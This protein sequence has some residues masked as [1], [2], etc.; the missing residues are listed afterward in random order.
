M[1]LIPLT[2]ESEIRQARETMLATL[3]RGCSRIIKRITWPSGG[4]EYSVHWNPRERFWFSSDYDGP[5]RWVTFF[6][7][8]DPAATTR[9]LN[10]VC[11]INPPKQGVDRQCAGMFV[12]DPEGHIYFTHSG[13]V[14]GT[15]ARI[16]K[17]V[18][19]S[20]YRGGLGT[21]SHNGTA[22]QVVVIGR[23]DVDN[24]VADVSNFIREVKRLKITLS[25]EIAHGGSNGVLPHTSSDPEFNPEF[26]G[27][28]RRFSV[29]SEIEALCTH[30]RVVNA[31]ADALR[32][33][34][35]NF[36]NDRRDLFVPAQNGHPGFLFEAKTDLSTTSIYQAIGQLLYHAAARTQS[37]HLVLVAPASPSER[38]R[39][40]LE[41]L[42]I[43]VLVY[44][45]QEQRPSF[46]SLTDI[47]RPSVPESARP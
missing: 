41:H 36:G 16:R 7:T 2:S 35:F 33:L 23:I 37:P 15:H 26:A 17:S 6:G 8:E 3:Q 45:W 34:G 31:L 14:G 18:F 21:V 20:R 44:D 12:R 25:E 42:G 1:T 39:H 11:E 46:R 13:K 22:F 43:S 29:Q 19:L 28:R 27:R 5:H 38:T 10:I 9:A 4:G 24:F 32:H 47:L 40:V 30:G